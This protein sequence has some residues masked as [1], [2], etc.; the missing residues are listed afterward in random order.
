MKTVL[1]L[2]E[3]HNANAD[4]VIAI[5]PNGKAKYATYAQITQALGNRH[6][7]LEKEVATLKEE[8][9]DLKTKI[10]TL[11]RIMKETMQ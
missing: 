3:R 10:A 1:D 4:S 5:G 11:A 6:D 2:P 8:V 7:A 9:S